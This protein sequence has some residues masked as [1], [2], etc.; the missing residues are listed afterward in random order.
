MRRLKVSIGTRSRKRE[1]RHVKLI[2]LVVLLSAMSLTACSDESSTPTNIPTP[3]PSATSTPT[4]TPTPVPTRTTTSETAPAD[5]PA[6]PPSDTPV[7]IAT[8]AEPTQLPPTL[9]PVPLPGVVQNLVVVSV[10]ED[11]ITLRW[12]PPAN[13]DVA[14]VER[15]EVTRDVSFGRDEHYFV[16]EPTLT[17]LG[18]KS[19]TEHKYRVRA[20]GVGGVEGEEVNIEVTTSDSMTSEPV[21]TPTPGP[22]VTSTP[23]PTATPRQ[24]QL[25]P[26]LTPVPLPGVVQ[27]LEVVSVTE[28]S[29]T[30]RWKPPANS[31]VAVVER[32]EVTRDVSFGRDEHHFVSVTMF[33]DAE[34]RSGTE[35]KYR[36]RAIGVGGVEGEETSIEGT[37]SDS[38]TSVSTPTSLAPTPGPADTAIHIPEEIK[39]IVIGIGDIS[40]YQSV[41]DAAITQDGSTL[42]LVLVVGAATSEEHAKELGENFVRMLKSL[43]QDEPPSIVIGTGIYDY[44]IGVYRP[45]QEQIA[46]GAK[47]RTA[48]RISW[49]SV[50]IPTPALTPTLP[51]TP[52]AAPD[53]PS[54]SIVDMD[55]W[56]GLVVAPEYRCSPYDSDAYRYSQSVEQQ[57]VAS[58][59]G[60]VYGPYTGRWFDSTSDTDIEH[61]VARSEAHDSGLCAVDAATKRQFASDLINLTLASPEVNRSQKSGKDAAEWLPDLN[62]CWFANRVV[63]VRKKFDLTIDERERDA[64]ESVLAGCTSTDMIVQEAPAQTATP[65]PT[66]GEGESSTALEMYDDNGNGRITCAE[67][68]NHGI[69][70][71]RRGHP[72]YEYMNDADNDGVV[73]E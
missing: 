64:V 8:T 35:H 21:S 48:D 73:C 55:I 43:S 24:T 37:T 19:G 5:T 56:R 30:L 20:I 1:F 51:A 31:D 28:D 53:S 36:V 69:A 63:E 15:Y 32:Y 25:P 14:V 16:T 71:V 11:S 47:A 41:Q 50:A 60:I 33:T 29:I 46:S 68:R 10:T 34:L 66:S 4:D 54:E 2:G 70:P 61:I 57:I 49:T 13:S 45:N 7:P 18:L 26:T 40:G 59:G 44:L 65:V 62:Q 22:P 58:M 9:T 67:A 52:T 12:K 39:E 38:V 42:S 27:N 17:H 23:V 72:A 6:S 3:V